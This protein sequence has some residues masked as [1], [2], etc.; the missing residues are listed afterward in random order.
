MRKRIGLVLASIHTGSSKEF[1]SDLAT[2]AKEHGDALFVFPGGRLECQDGFEFLRNEIYM[3][4]NAKNLDGL[5]SW[6][7]SLGEA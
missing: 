3:L 4:A 5:V 2:L 6:G 7:S 1:W